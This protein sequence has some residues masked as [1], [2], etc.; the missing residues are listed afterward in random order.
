MTIE[1][2]EHHRSAVEGEAM[3]AVRAYAG[4]VVKRFGSNVRGI[5]LFGSR[6]RGDHSPDSDADVAIVLRD[7]DERPIEL[8]LDLVDLAYDFTLRAGIHI[9]PWPFRAR[10]WDS[11]TSPLVTN[12]RGDAVSIVVRE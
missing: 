7:F 8:K 5:Y 12:A 11:G 3:A 2:R 10:D 9:S 4:E 1:T 6:A